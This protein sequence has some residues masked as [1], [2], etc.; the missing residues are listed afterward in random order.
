MFISLF[1][2]KM[3]IYRI[4]RKYLFLSREEEIKEKT[5][6]SRRDIFGLGAIVSSSLGDYST[7]RVEV[8]PENDTVTIFAGR[9]GNQTLRG[10]EINKSYICKK[11]LHLRYVVP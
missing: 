4:H 11:L 9:T 6:F 7:E 1:L 8:D 2:S 10:H 3:T 5:R